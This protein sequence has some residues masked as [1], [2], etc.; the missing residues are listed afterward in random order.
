MTPRERVEAEIQFALVDAW[1]QLDEAVRLAEGPLWTTALR[2][3]WFKRLKALRGCVLL[4]AGRLIDIVHVE[5]GYG[6][7]FVHSRSKRAGVSSV[8]TSNP[9][10]KNQVRQWA[11]LCPQGFP[12]MRFSLGRL[13][14]WI[15]KG[16]VELVHFFGLRS[17]VHRRVQEKAREQERRK[18]L[19]ESLAVHD[20]LIEAAA[21]RLTTRQAAERAEHE[22]LRK[23]REARI[24]SEATLMRR[25]AGLE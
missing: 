12:D 21:E 25:R 23:A 18:R 8:I 9:D 16:E 11:L 17:Q 20:A 1:R 10:L 22:K 5:Q 6:G 2:K 19:L 15:E 3:E 7:Q 13:G 14:D 4:A 24:V